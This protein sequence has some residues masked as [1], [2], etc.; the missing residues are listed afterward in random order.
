MKAKKLVVII[1][2]IVIVAVGANVLRSAVSRS[3]AAYH[4]PPTAPDISHEVQWRPATAA[5]KAGAEKAI[6]GQL[7]V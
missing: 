6:I 7:D 4:A 5:E 2:M 1:L 3:Q